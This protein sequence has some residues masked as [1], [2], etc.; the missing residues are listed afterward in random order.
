MAVAAV[1][2]QAREIDQLKRQVDLVRRESTEVRRSWKT[3][4]VS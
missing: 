1:R 3:V 2:E 4:T